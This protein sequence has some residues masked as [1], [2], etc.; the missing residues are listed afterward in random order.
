M[1]ASLR[2]ASLCDS[3]TA[4]LRQLVLWCA[5]LMMPSQK[6]CDAQVQSPD[7]KKVLCSTRQSPAVVYLLTCRQAPT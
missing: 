3:R 6:E 7:G 5:F 4:L 1:S 2:Y